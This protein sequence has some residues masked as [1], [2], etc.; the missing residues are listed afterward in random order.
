MNCYVK[1]RLAGDDVLCVCENCSTFSPA[2]YQDCHITFLPYNSTG[3][4]D[5]ISLITSLNSWGMSAWCFLPPPSCSLKIM[6]RLKF[7][8]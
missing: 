1:R 2:C 5:T 4:V 8:N 6:E 7:L 3:L